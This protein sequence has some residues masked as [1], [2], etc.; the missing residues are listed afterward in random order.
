MLVVRKIR[1]SFGTKQLFQ[2]ASFALARGQRV[3]LVGPNGAGKST[4]LKMIAG[5][6][7]LEKG[8]IDIGERT[9]VGY[10]AQ[11]SLAE[12]DETAL[13]YLRRL[14]GVTT[15][16]AEMAALEPKLDQSEVLEAYERLENDYRRLGGYQFLDKAKG[17][18]DGLALSGVGLDRP[19]R[20]LSGGEKR[21]LSLA[22]VLLRGVD[23][24]L[25]DEPTNN[26]DLPALLWLERYL[27]ALPVALLVA[28]HDRT[29]LDRV[30]EKVLEIDTV[31]HALVLYSGNWSVYAETK[32]HAFRRAKELYRAQEEERVRVAASAEEK[33]RWVERTKDRPLRD[34][35]KFAAN[36]KKERAIRKF[37]TS[38]KALEGRLK[39]LDKYEKPFERIPLTFTFPAAGKTTPPTLALERAVLGYRKGTPLTRPSSLRI[40]FGRRVAL[41]GTN[42]AGKSTLLKTLSKKMKPLAG[43]VLVSRSVL[44]GDLMQEHEN[45]P[46]HMTPIQYFSA[47]LSCHD[48]E[49]ARFL[50]AR[51]GFSPDAATERINRLS[52]GER[53]RFIMATLVERGANVLLLDEPTNHLDL[54]A[55]EALEEALAVYPG[56]FLLVS[57]DRAFL[58]HVPIDDFYVLESGKLVR[59][60]DFRE[61]AARLERSAARRLK[62]L[63]EK[64]GRRG[65]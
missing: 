29:F 20:M 43:K 1:K 44:F 45:I 54:E 58:A 14:A 9:L 46:A 47:A 26:L 56:T 52:P 22:A 64:V 63:S 17:V 8:E 50:L 48:A 2:Q 15:L 32:A 41:L 65:A 23:L 28:S 25:L 6:E 61:Y 40:P 7:S 34:G 5:L 53:V 12:G 60:P 27:R 30:A 13:A 3:A 62:R 57:H 36:F 55:I 24:L 38:A 11:E 39:R 35:D 10:L 21:K 4:L 42:G 51:F 33:M 37:T 19:V 16:E 18:L 31:K 49:R 59:L